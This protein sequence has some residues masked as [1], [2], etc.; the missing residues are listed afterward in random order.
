MSFC[1]T[2]GSIGDII[3]VG[4]I[5]ISLVKALRSGCGS[6]KEYQSLVRELENFDKALLQVGISIPPHIGRP[7]I[8]NNELGH[9]IMAKL[10]PL[11]LPSRPP[12]GRYERHQ[13]VSG[14]LT[15]VL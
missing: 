10:R 12:R 1:I 11:P 9:S 15:L 3:A 6:A 4:Q 5:A 8:L 13:A 14:M 2:F 7:L